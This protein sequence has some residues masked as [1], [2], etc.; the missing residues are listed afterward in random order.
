MFI[1]AGSTITAATS[2]GCAA[3]TRSSPAMSLNGATEVSS[4]VEAGMPCVNGT[5]AGCS[6]GPISSGSG[7]TETSSASW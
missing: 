3:K 4:T 2:V 6:T 7:S 1:I 5:D